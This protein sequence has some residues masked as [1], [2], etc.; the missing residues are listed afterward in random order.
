MFSS[1]SCRPEQG[2]F[3]AYRISGGVGE[4]V[5]D[6]FFLFRARFVWVLTTNICIHKYKTTSPPV[7]RHRRFLLAGRYFVKDAD[8]LSGLEK[9]VV[10][11]EE[12][13]LI[14]DGG[15]CFK[16]DALRVFV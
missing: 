4:R 14:E 2:S 16:W 13:V 11:G 10:W 15:D 6:C 5:G 9:R 1:Y 7:F 3:G 8:Y 12:F